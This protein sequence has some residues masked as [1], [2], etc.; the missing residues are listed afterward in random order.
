MSL[1]LNALTTFTQALVRR[2]TLAGEEKAAA[3]LVAAEMQRLGYDQVWIDANGS[4]VGIIMG[5]Q[6]TGAAL[7]I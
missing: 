5:A 7:R 3:E 1:D 6:S 4:V 2:P